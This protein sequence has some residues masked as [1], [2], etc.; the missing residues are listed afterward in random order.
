MN[1]DQFKHLIP[2]LAERDIQAIEN[3][4]VKEHFASCASCRQEFLS[5]QQAWNMLGDLPSVE[6]QPNYIS[7][8]WTRVAVEQPWYEE[9]WEG[10]KTT[11]ARKRWVPVLVG[12]Y[13]LIFIG[14]FSLQ[15][16]K[17]N[18]GV[19]PEVVE[20]NDNDLEMVENIDLAE[21]L[22]IVQDLDFLEDL[23]VIENLESLETSA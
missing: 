13:A 16:F 1:C 9:A 10:L 12:I 20:I 15:Y 4:E 8:F 7:R 11:F 2:E 21:S 19:V 23:D 17:G 22:D 18:Q 3:K 6:P 5:V 14:I